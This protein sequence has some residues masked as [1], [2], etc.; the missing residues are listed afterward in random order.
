VGLVLNLLNSQ[1]DD[2]TFFEKLERVLDRDTRPFI[3]SLW[4]YV[5]FEQL[6]LK[7][8]FRGR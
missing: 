4:R 5:I 6:K 3:K 2:R 8:P 7:S 1:A